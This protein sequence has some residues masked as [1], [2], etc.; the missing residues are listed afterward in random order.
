MGANSGLYNKIRG[1]ER[2]KLWSAG[3]FGLFYPR[4]YGK[5]PGLVLIQIDGLSKMQLESAL[6][7]GR[8]PFIRGILD[9]G[10]YRN[11]KLY[12]GMPS[13]TSSGEAELFY[14]VKNTTSFNHLDTETGRIFWNNEARSVKET[15]KRLAQSG[16]GLLKNGSSYG[17]IFS[18]GASS[19]YERSG[20]GGFDRVWRGNKPFRLIL[21]LGA[22]F[23]SLAKTLV[24]M[25]IELVLAA[26]DFV[27]G[28]LKG[29]GAWREFMML[30]GRLY[31]SV[32]LRDIATLAVR[33]DITAGVPVIYVNYPG[34]DLQAHRR[35]PSSRY[36]RWALRG[37][38]RSVEKIWRK[39]H[40]F[41]RR[42]YDVWIFSGHGQEEA[43]PWPEM[44][45]RKIIKTIR[46]S[47]RK[48]APSA[49]KGERSEFRPG[50]IRGKGLFRRL[51]SVLSRGSGIHLEGGF[52]L[53]APGPMSYLY[54]A[55]KPSESGLETLGAEL[56]AVAPLVVKPSAAGKAH[57]WLGGRKY[58]LPDEY[59][60]VLGGHPFAE[61]AARDLALYASKDDTGD[62]I[63]SGYTPGRLS[64]SF[65]G[66]KGSH[67]G[68]GPDAT[69]GFALIPGRVNLDEKTEN[70]VRLEDIRNSA[71][72]V[73][74]RRKRSAPAFRGVRRVRVMTYNI[75]S[76]IGLDREI[77]PERAARVIGR[78]DPDIV[79]LQEVDVMRQR[80]GGEDQAKIIASMLEMYHKHHPHIHMKEEKYGNVILSRFPL[81]LVRSDRLPGLPESLGLDPR[82]AIW[83]V[84]DA[85]GTDIH[86]INTHFGLTHRERVKQAA[87]I[88]GPKWLGSADIGEDPVILCGDLNAPAGSAPLKM[89]GRK[90]DDAQ[91]V[92]EGHIPLATWFSGLPFRR[93]DHV[94]ISENFEVVGVHVPR[95]RLERC[96]SDH[97]PIITDLR[98]K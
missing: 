33:H 25:L 1:W 59:E 61:E 49:L 36:A 13:T 28:V 5:K 52:L 15:E 37:I 26:M 60:H 85:E 45:R 22:N 30:T 32:I 19:H 51:A 10:G 88:C 66:E 11:I 79:A 58:T 73:L 70:A 16:E 71:L 69:S 87:E 44:E 80:T 56:S 4:Y 48:N 53:T 86:I 82:S 67:G 23:L 6:L 54:L 17:G 96:V 14:G 92:M 20:T 78:Y 43:E 95:T 46:E 27:K 18:G 38:D 72:R 84:A 83:A 35:G 89:I 39:A 64:L 50:G 34:Y 74:G 81:R 8:M 93:I 90:L 21:V 63:L 7:D 65:P 57:A 12:S 2:W 41:K 98:L 42:E 94:L 55:E 75:Q 77:S 3:L 31:V 97:L 68:P 24:Y 47:L 62:L 29:S 9:R 76:C 40:K 91:S